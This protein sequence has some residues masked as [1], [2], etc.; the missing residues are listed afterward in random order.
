[1]TE[2][3]SWRAERRGWPSQV[4]EDA[5]GGRRTAAVV[6]RVVVGTLGRATAV[7]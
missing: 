1:M 6:N 7:F 2:Y 4:S 5:D 3:F